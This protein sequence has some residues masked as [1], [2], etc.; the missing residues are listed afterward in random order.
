MVGTNNLKKALRPLEVE[1][2][3]LPL[4]A[5]LRI[6]PTSRI[7]VWGLFKRKDICDEYVDQSNR[8]ILEMFE[9]MNK[10]L[11]DKIS[12]LEAPPKITKEHLVDHR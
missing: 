6:S 11:G 5:L 10:H 12:W 4:R 2:Y 9:G 7:V 3:R 1:R 8:L